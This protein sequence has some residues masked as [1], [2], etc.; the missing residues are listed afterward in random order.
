MK[1]SI[2]TKLEQLAS[3]LAE[4]DA[5]LASPEATSNMDQ[6]RKMT[7]EHADITPVV[8]RFREYQ[9]AE[10]DITEAQS[11]LSDA[12]MKEYAEAEIKSGKERILSLEGELQKLLL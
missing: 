7:R 9:Q 11:M 2:A 3:R 8:E 4:I 5:L 12:E 10:R 6:F 1:P